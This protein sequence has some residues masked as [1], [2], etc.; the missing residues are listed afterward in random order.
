MSHKRENTRIRKP[1]NMKRD[2]LLTSNASVYDWC[3]LL[4]TWGEKKHR[5]VKEVLNVG[6]LN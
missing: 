6:W 3:T 4:L 2:V 1:V 5:K